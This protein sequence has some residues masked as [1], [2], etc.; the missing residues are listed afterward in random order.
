MSDDPAPPAPAARTYDPSVLA[1]PDVR[2]EA[3]SLAWV[4]ATLRDVPSDRGG[5]Y[6]EGSYTDAEIRG[7]LALHGVKNADGET[8]YAPHVAAAA[9]IESDPRRVL[10][11]GM[12]GLSGTLPNA[13]D[14]AARIVANG[15]AIDAMIVQAGGA[16]PR[17]GGSR[18]VPARW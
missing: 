8:L 3:W 11:F 13:R 15:A 14:V 4:R 16:P 1:T 17:P 12:A 5:A 7:F 9:M 10:A 18:T 2:S 6:P